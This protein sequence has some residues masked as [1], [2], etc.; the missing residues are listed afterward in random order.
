MNSRCSII[1]LCLLANQSRNDICYDSVI[2]CLRVLIVAECCSFFGAASMVIWNLW[3]GSPYRWIGFRVIETYQINSADVHT[4][5]YQWPGVASGRVICFVSG[6]F[7]LLSFPFEPRR[8]PLTRRSCA[9]NS[10]R[11]A[12]DFEDRVCY[13][14]TVSANNS[15]YI[16]QEHD[17]LRCPLC[18]H[19]LKLYSGLCLVGSCLSSRCPRTRAATID[20]ERWRKSTTRQW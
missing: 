5:K 16:R 18:P 13:L 2:T 11:K 15:D 12:I 20:C 9:V 7:R 14:F 1:Q 8:Y 6:A 17:Y 10:R 3:H 19:Y 4:S